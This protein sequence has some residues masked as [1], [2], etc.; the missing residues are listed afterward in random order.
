MYTIP[1]RARGP[2]PIRARIPCLTLVPT[3]CRSAENRR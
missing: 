3:R 2:T 1:T